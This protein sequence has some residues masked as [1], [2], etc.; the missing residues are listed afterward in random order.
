MLDNE[1]ANLSVFVNETSFALVIVLVVIAAAFDLKSRRIPNWLVLAGLIVSLAYQTLAPTGAGFSSWMGGLAVGFG[2]FLPL[3]LLRTMGAGDVKLMAAVGS[4][5]GASVTLG[6]IL[7][8]L[9]VG[10]FL[11]VLYALLCRRMRILMANL[12]FMATDL[13]VK[14]A[15]G[16][17]PQTVA[18]AESAGKIPYG[19]A[20]AVGTLLQV[21]LLH[22]G[23]AFF[24]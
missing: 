2:I 11:A 20:I 1:F 13:V 7:L 21:Y 9:V 4:F 8:T 10:G 19:V 5:L 18:P 14:V 3:Y 15:I 22:A 23:H 6:A 17:V 24:A 16:E 12:R